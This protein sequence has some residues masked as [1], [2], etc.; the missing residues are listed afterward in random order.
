MVPNVVPGT[1]FRT[2]PGIPTGPNDLLMPKF[3]H[4]GSFATN[5]GDKI[6]KKL[7]FQKW[8]QIWSPGTPFGTPPGTPFGTPPGTPRGLKFFWGPGY[9]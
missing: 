2:P 4:L 3:I 8:S 1:P 9:I 7:N 6:I 5:F